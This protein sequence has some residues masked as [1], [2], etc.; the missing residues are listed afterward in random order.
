MHDHMPCR[1]RSVASPTSAAIER[2]T[3]FGS[4]LRRSAASTRSAQRRRP[5]A[6]SPLDTAYRT[7]SSSSRKHSSNISNV[8]D[9][10]S[11]IPPRAS[12]DKLPTA[13]LWRA[14]ARCRSIPSWRAKSSEAFAALPDARRTRAKMRRA[15]LRRRRGRSGQQL[16]GPARDLLLRRARRPRTADHRLLAVGLERRSAE[17]SQ[18]DGC[19]TIRCG[20]RSSCN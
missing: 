2:V 8:S 20:W 13:R 18:P 6:H 9:S 12:R 14:C 11:A 4:T 1:V 19:R 7:D 15:K 5:L 16:C 17:L 10:T 3:S